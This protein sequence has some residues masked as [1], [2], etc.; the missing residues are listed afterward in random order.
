MKVEVIMSAY[1]NPRDLKL[2]LDSYVRQTYKNFSI[3]IADDGSESTIEA[4]IKTYATL[5]IRHVWQEDKG[6]RKAKILNKAIK[7][8][9]AEYIIF[10]DADCIASS[11]FIH[12]HMD[13]ASSS[14][15]VIGVRVYIKKKLSTKLRENRLD[16]IKL[17]SGVWLVVQSILGRL[18]K[19]EQALRY[20]DWSLPYLHKIKSSMVEF[21]SNIAIPMENLIQ[22]NGFDEDFQGWGY[23]DSDL[24]RRLY[25]T[26]LTPKGEFGR[27][28]QYHLQH[29]V[30]AE[31]DNALDMFMSKTKEKNIQCKHGINTL[32]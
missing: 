17:D 9:T 1:N 12:D 26:G 13:Q 29:K 15:V 6:F 30:N 27:C 25:L 4:L 20:P 21:G 8:S 23:E 2:A 19:P 10:T 7:T 24:L 18:T 28:V 16:P 11:M 31:N 32:E 3:C 5:N 14:H 22:I